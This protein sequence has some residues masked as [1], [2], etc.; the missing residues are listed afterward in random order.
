MHCFLDYDRVLLQICDAHR[1]GWTLTPT[2]NNEIPPNY[3]EWILFE[4]QLLRDGQRVFRELK[5]YD[6]WSVS[7]HALGKKV[8]PDEL[9]G[10]TDLSRTKKSITKVSFLNSGVSFL[11]LICGCLNL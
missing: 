6:D 10:I 4:G 1:F 9:G 2:L 3:I 11:E 7:I 5:I 8:H